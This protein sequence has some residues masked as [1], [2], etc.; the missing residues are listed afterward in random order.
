MCNLFLS[1]ELINNISRKIYL[2]QE[3]PGLYVVATPIGNIF[4]ISLR[5]LYI[6]K[7]VKLIFAEDTRN[8]KKLLNFFEI[9]TPLIACHEYNEIL[10][11]VTNK[12]HKGESY[13]LISDAGT[14]TISDPGYRLINWCIQQGIDVFP[15]PGACAFIA[16]LSASGMPTDSFT[17]FGFLPTREQARLKFLQNIK[18]NKETLIFLES[19]NRILNTLNNMLAIL[20][21]RF[22]CICREIT[23]VFEEFIRGNLNEVINS[24]GS[25]KIH[26]EFIIILRGEK[27]NQADNINIVVSE[28]ADLL[29]KYSLKETVSIISKKYQFNKHIIYQKALELKNE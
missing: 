29:N 13:A 27:Q 6:L 8:S 14:P 22:C 28:L 15:V 11:Q 16:G 17:F 10:S 20:G 9:N 12:I 2:Q 23:K 26:G 1:S 21:N 5:A 19:P 4:D 7:K 25:K 3:K 18:N 24:L